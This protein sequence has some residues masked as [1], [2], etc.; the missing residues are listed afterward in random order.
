M[1]P[2]ETL[3]VS[4]LYL[5]GRASCCCQKW[6]PRWEAPGGMNRAAESGWQARPAWSWLCNQAKWEGRDL[7]K[8][9]GTGR[10][11]SASRPSP[12]PET[13]A[14]SPEAPQALPQVH[15][16]IHPKAVP[17]RDNGRASSHTSHGPHFTDEETEAREPG[18]QHEGLPQEPGSP[19]PAPVGPASVPA[20]RG[21]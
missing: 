15:Q 8:A 10:A 13:D 12:R 11:S 4:E 21:T 3:G 18:G 14:R 2:R 19:F 16:K 9:V 20:A 5:C 6:A 1:G 7:L 17:I